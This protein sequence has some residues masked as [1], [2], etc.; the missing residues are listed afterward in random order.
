MW[1]GAALAGLLGGG[2]ANIPG[3]INFLDVVI[4]GTGA[5]RQVTGLGGSITIRV[6]VTNV[7]MPTGGASIWV[8]K[9]GVFLTSETL[10][11]GVDAEFDF[12][13]GNDLLR[14]GAAGGGPPGWSMTADV[15]LFY[16]S[17]EGGAFDTSWDTFSII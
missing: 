10:Y 8:L 1:P 7:V 12:E 11:G 9:N 17:V 13:T 15:E 5:S 14:F 4:G 2:G 6:A 3:A 16:Q